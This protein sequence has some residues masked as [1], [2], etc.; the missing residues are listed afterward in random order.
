[1]SKCLNEET[2]DDVIYHQLLAA[3]EW[4]DDNYDFDCESESNP[5]GD[6][7]ATTS[8][9]PTEKSLEECD[10]DFVAKFDV[11]D[12]IRDYLIESDTFCELITDMVE[13]KFGK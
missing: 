8:R 6:T 2:F 4:H 5:Y 13:R 11:V 3:K 1:M 7:W 9:E 12:F 10:E